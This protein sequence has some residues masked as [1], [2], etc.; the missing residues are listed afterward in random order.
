MQQNATFL[1]FCRCCII[2]W[3]DRADRCAICSRAARDTCAP[4]AVRALRVDSN[5][6]NSNDLYSSV[7]RGARRWRD[8]SAALRLSND[9]SFLPAF[10][11]YSCI[12]GDLGKTT[13]A[14]HSCPGCRAFTRSACP[15]R[16]R[17]GRPKT[18]PISLP[19]LPSPSIPQSHP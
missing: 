1:A 15:E 13:G 17:G 10:L 9:F 12:P 5:A 3:S 14:D 8:T 4:R 6:L 19:L 7:A 18:P 2:L 16:G 11:D